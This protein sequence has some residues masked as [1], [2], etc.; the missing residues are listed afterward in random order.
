LAIDEADKEKFNGVTCLTAKM[1]HVL[2]KAI[3]IDQHVY[4]A[5]EHTPVVRDHFCW[6]FI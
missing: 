1:L 5:S 2:F 6:L 4:V 3:F